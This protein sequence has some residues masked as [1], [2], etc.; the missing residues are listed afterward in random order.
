[1]K[2]PTDPTHGQSRKAQANSAA[3][4]PVPAGNGIAE[5]GKAGPGNKHSPQWPSEASGCDV[6]P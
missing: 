6:P 3:S 5:G 4:A 2:G 1:M